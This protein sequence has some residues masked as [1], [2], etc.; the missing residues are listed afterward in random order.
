MESERPFE[1]WPETTFRQTLTWIRTWTWAL[2]IWIQNICWKLSRG[3][4][5]T[6]SS[7][8]HV[9]GNLKLE[10]VLSEDSFIKQSGKRACRVSTISKTHSMANPL[11]CFLGCCNLGLISDETTGLGRFSIWVLRPAAFS[12]FAALAVRQYFPRRINKAL[13]TQPVSPS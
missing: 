10:H 7:V 13:D 5:D 8:W 3:H 2:W 12:F 4:L 11:R 9:S 1:L 6:L